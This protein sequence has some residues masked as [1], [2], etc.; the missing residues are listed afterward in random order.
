MIETTLPS[1][2]RLK[3]LIQNHHAEILSREKNNDKF[4]HLYSIGTY[5]VAFEQSACLMNDIFPWCELSLFMVPDRPGYVVM[6]SVPE[7]K[8]TTYFR[9]YTI[10]RDGLN[11]KILKANPLSAEHYHKWHIGAVRSV[12]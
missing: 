11:Y 5:W 6:A 1:G 12:L 7:D 9:K 2:I 8:A 4:V 10:S 3:N